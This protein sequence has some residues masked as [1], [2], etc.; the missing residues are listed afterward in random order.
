[1]EYN[2]PERGESATWFTECVL[3]E[4]I[5]RAKLGEVEKWISTAVLVFE[6]RMKEVL[7]EL[8]ADSL[9]FVSAESQSVEYVWDH[10][11]YTANNINVPVIIYISACGEKKECHF[12]VVC[13]PS[14]VASPDTGMLKMVYCHIDGTGN[15]ETYTLGITC[16]PQAVSVEIKK[17]KPAEAIP[18]FSATT[19]IGSGRFS[20]ESFAKMLLSAFGDSM[21][22]NCRIL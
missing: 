1:M 19:V 3:K 15:K 5:L 6:E 18:L 4:N 20:S 2:I 9:F 17:E 8:K 21:R 11:C 13:E 22:H 16:N 12:E 7:V 10:F 14:F